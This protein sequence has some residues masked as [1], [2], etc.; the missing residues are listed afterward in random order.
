MVGQYNSIAHCFPYELIDPSAI[1]LI[2]SVF[3]FYS[4]FKAARLDQL[5]PLDDWIW[6]KFQSTIL[7]PE[8]LEMT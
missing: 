8:D 3:P 2:L 6:V 5:E 1:D 7:H 4:Q